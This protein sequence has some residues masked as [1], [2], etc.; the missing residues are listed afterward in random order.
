[1][2]AHRLSRWTLAVALAP[3]LVAG[4]VAPVRAAGPTPPPSAAVASLMRADPTAADLTTRLEQE[5]EGVNEDPEV[6]AP[7]LRAVLD[8]LEQH[9]GIVGRDPAL[10]QMRIEGLLYLAR[11]ELVL[12][13]PEQAADAVDEAIRVSGGTVPRIADFGPSLADL[14]NERQASPELRQ[15]GAITV[16]CTGGPCRVFLDG[17]VLGTG[18]SVSASGVPLGPHMLRIEPQQ[19]TGDADPVRQERITISDA[20]PKQEFT[21]EVPSA[22][23]PIVG[24]EPKSN[25]P[26]SGRKLPRWA[27]ILGM[28][29][30]GV[31]MAGG[32]FAIAIDGRCPDL[33]DATP[34]SGD[35]CRDVHK[36]MVTGIVLASAGAASLTGFGIAFGVGQAKDKRHAQQRKGT[37]AALQLSWRF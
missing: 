34:T 27:G 23:Q 29:L 21:F 15:I 13:Q 19:R 14:Y 36:S 11:A 8:E 16:T 28:T 9:P 31:A 7:T 30:S 5:I 10:A 26:G 17:R 18:A 6:H 20:E 4:V 3:A 35:A 25:D 37:T 22:Q 24:T 12:E 2:N 33:T 32:I 1:M